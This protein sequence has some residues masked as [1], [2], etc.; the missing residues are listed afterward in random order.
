MVEISRASLAFCA[1]QRKLLYH[2]R[3]A[4]RRFTHPFF[5]LA[6]GTLGEQTDDMRTTARTLF[7]RQIPPGRYGFDLSQLGMGVSESSAHAVPQ[8]HLQGGR[9]IRRRLPAVYS[10]VLGN[11]QQW[12]RQRPITASAQFHG[13]APSR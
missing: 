7:R 8:H 1:W 10:M 5:G 2:Q 13:F 9:Q 11:A 4:L 12:A 3:L 6:L